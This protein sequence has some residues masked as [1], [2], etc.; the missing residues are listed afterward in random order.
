MHATKMEY[1]KILTDLKVLK[2]FTDNSEILIE[3][4]LNIFDLMSTI[5]ISDEIVEECI[6]QLL[7][8]QLSFCDYR[9]DE[10]VKRFLKW[11]CDVYS[12]NSAVEV[13]ALRAITKVVKSIEK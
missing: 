1:E 7:R 10:R 12:I 5:E 2:N 4:S 11:L 8:I 13:Y 6:G 3:R 9:D